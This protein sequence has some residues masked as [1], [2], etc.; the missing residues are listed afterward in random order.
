MPQRGE[1]LRLEGVGKG[2]GVASDQGTEGW[3][4]VVR[5]V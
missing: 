5:Q 3:D 2:Q 4:S 1:G